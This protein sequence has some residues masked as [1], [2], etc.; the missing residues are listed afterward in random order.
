MAD[1]Y[2]A[3]KYGRVKLGTTVIAEAD[4][5]DMTIAADAAH[6]G[7]FGGGGWKF[8]VTGQKGGTG[9]IGGVYDFDVPAEDNIVVG[10]QY[11][12]ELY[13]STVTGGDAQFYTLTLEII[14]FN[15]VVDANDQPIRWTASWQS[16]GAITDP[17]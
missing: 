11:S 10:T 8:S 14:D 3:G 4:K 12:A 15:V 7:T 9:T 6:F 13:E 2:R 17:S 16:H 5:W 1:D